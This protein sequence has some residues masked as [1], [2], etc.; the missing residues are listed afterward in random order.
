MS[1]I[2]ISQFVE[3]LIAANEYLKQFKFPFDGQRKIK[4]EKYT[5]ILPT[6]IVNEIVNNSYYLTWSQIYQ[7]V[8]KQVQDFQ[9]DGD[10]Y[11][12]IPNEGIKSELVILAATW[13]S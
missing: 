10:F 9:P 7:A 11:I 6:E 2:P 5:G 8:R 3:Q 1:I 12:Y 13:V 4:V